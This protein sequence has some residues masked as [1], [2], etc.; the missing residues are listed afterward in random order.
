MLPY[1]YNITITDLDLQ[2]NNQTDNPDDEEN[3]ED[4]QD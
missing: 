1:E 4:D 3:S 2:Q